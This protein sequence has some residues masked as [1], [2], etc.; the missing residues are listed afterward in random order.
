M[1]LINRVKATQ[2]RTV[3]VDDSHQS[4]IDNYGN[5]NFALTIAIA[6][7]VTWKLLD[8]WYQLRGLSLGCCTAY[9]TAKSYRLARYL[10]LKWPKDELWFL[11]RAFWI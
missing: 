4:P 10:S 7:N 3:D 2:F 6:S 8:V 11:Y 1:L 5:H 9:A